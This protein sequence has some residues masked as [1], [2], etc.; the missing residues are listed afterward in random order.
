MSTPESI[1]H[2]L[3]RASPDTF[4][5]ACS[6][7]IELAKP[8]LNLL[9]TT[10]KNKPKKSKS[11][12]STQTHGLSQQT[13]ASLSAEREV[14]AQAAETAPRPPARPRPQSRPLRRLCG[15]PAPAELKPINPLGK[16]P[17][18]IY[19]RSK[20]AGKDAKQQIEVKSNKPGSM[21]GVQY[22][23]IYTC[24]DMYRFIIKHVYWFIIYIGLWV[25]FV[26]LELICDLC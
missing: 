22:L 8:S 21:R 19:P 20:K 14:N 18:C 26:G 24:I 7:P 16:E 10:Q 25:A 12:Y 13:A 17:P 15:S 3:S 6:L 11:D 1:P 23:Y 2:L 9:F 4:V 5:P